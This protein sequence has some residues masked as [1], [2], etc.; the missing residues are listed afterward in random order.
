MMNEAE[1]RRG[2]QQS[3]WR[4]QR[5]KRWAGRDTTAFAAAVKREVLKLERRGEKV[6]PELLKWAKN[7]EA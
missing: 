7:V 6:Q 1:R 4:S 5:E 3:Y 2:L